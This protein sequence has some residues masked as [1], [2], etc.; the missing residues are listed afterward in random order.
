MR[1]FVL[2]RGLDHPCHFI[3]HGPSLALQASMGLVTIAGMAES[4]DIPMREPLAYFLTWTTYGTWLPGDQRGWIE[5]PG[6]FREPNRNMEVANREQ[7]TEPEFVLT[8]PQRAL[9]ELTIRDHCK[10]R[11]WSLHA[12][13]CRTNHVHVVVT[14]P[15]Y[16]PDDVMKQFKSWCTR[17]L[18]EHASNPEAPA[19]GPTKNP[20]NSLPLTLRQK[21]WTRGG[22]K[23]VIFDQEGM[24]NAIVYALDGQ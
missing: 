11:R 19:S 5:K 20:A 7:M 8:S 24:E 13:N 1:D 16:S 17:R 18:K 14:A 22:S 9:V 10:F 6:R 23:R 12:V 15:G 3:V 21:F 4:G 2:P